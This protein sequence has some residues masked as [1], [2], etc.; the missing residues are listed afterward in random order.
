MNPKIP[1]YTYL[2]IYEPILLT[3]M[4]SCAVFSVSSL[5]QCNPASKET[6]TNN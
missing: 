2:H 5:S 1:V 3:D 4:G 6:Q